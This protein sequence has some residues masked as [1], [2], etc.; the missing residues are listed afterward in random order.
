MHYCFISGEPDTFDELCF[1]AVLFEQQKLPFELWTHRLSV[2]EIL[3][4]WE[5]NKMDTENRRF[6]PLSVTYSETCT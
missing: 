3:P 1:A 4:L 2:N 5:G 6:M